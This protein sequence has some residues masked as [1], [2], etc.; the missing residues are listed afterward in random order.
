MTGG[1]VVA[2]GPLHNLDP[3]RTAGGFDHGSVS[4]DGHV[5]RY[6]NEYMTVD[7]D[8]ERIATYPDVIATLSLEDGRPVSIAEM[9]EGRDVALFV[10]D[11][12]LLPLSSS[13]RDRFALEEVER[14]MGVTLIGYGPAESSS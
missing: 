14:I 1:R 9:T 4:V 12:S 8:G 10:V 5:V 6:L 3:L 7:L 11:R 2:W 13:T